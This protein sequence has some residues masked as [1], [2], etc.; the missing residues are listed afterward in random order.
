MHA[1]PQTELFYEA[2]REKIAGTPY[3]VTPTPQGFDLALDLV[4]AKWFGAFNM[5]GLTS[6]YVHHVTVVPNG[7]YQILDD[8]V[9]FTWSA[10]VPTAFRHERFQGRIHEVSFE[11]SWGITESGEFGK[12]TDYTFRTQE[13]RQV[14]RTAANS[15]GLKEKMPAA[16]VI[17]LTFAI[18][19]DLGAVLAMV[20][21]GV[22]LLAS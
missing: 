19:G 5:A 4:N 2:V 13:G 1:L 20:I 9:T 14:I 12:I 17:G 7:T 10:G 22:G 3:I 21:L 15:L 18:I 8:K 16:M 6:S 11:K